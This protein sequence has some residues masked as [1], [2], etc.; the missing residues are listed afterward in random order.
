MMASLRKILGAQADL[1][2]VVGLMVI[3]MVLFAPIPPVLLDFLLISNFSIALLVLLLTFYMAKPLEFSTFP[4][5][6]LMATLFRLALNVSATRLV[7]RDAYAGDVISSVGGYVVGGNYVIGL[8]VFVVL[9]VVQYVVVTNGAQRVAE[10]AARFTLD[11]MP[12][13]QMAVDADLNMGLI[14]QDQ[15][16]ERRRP[17]TLANN[18]LLQGR[19]TSPQGT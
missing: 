17:A 12:G 16:R 14:D 2:L 15:A 18:T 11:S 13:K 19:H 3:L 1:L 7:L 10:V 8:I 5:L 6:L 9:I 4:S